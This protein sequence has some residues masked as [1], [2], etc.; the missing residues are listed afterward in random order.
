MET[1]LIQELWDVLPEHMTK[2]GQKQSK[3]M[4]QGFGKGY[5]RGGA[6]AAGVGVKGKKRDS[7]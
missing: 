6:Q 7:I 4:E 5:A 1:V 2:K 3:Y